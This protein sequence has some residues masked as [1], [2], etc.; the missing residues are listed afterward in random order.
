MELTWDLTDLFINDEAFYEEITNINSLIIKLED[1]RN[2]KFDEDSLYDAL[3]LY[4]EIKKRCNNILVYGSLKY[5]QNVNSN[6]TIKLK[7]DAEVFHNETNLKIQYIESQIIAMGRSKI[8]SLI[9]NNSNL[10]IYEHYLDNLFRIQAHIK[11]E[12]NDVLKENNNEI[13]KMLT[14]YNSIINNISYGTIV[15]NGKEETVTNANIN[16]Y[17]AAS[18]REVRSNAYTLIN[19]AYANHAKEIALILN[20]IYHKRNQNASLEEYDS[21][22]NK[23]LSEENINPEIIKIL[24][25]SI[26]DNLA[27][28]QKY[29]KIKADR[30]NIEHPHLYDYNV[31]LVMDL[32]IEFSIEEAINIIKAA[33]APLGPDYLNTIDYLLSGHIDATLNENKHQSIIFSWNTYSF[34]NY[35]GKYFDLKNL[36]HELGH[37]INYHF[38]KNNLPYLYED[39]SVFVG[40]IASIVNELLLS[41]YLIDHAKNDQEKLFYLS[42]EVE[43]YVTSVYKQVMYTEYENALYELSKNSE[44]TPELLSKEYEKLLH[45]YYGNNTIY[46]QESNIEWTRIGKLFRHSYYSYK[47]ATGLIM[48]SIV[49]NNI[50]NNTLSA[51]D[52]IKFLQSGSS[53]YSLDL[54]KTINIDLS[55]LNIIKTGFTGLEKDINEIETILK[56]Q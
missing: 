29:L 32:N 38:S 43:N 51:D 52:Y 23:V 20:D 56:V 14:D 55:D 41:R 26:N 33:L 46:D 40:E 24:I 9:N 2:Q 15:V 44:L 53:M 37:I 19:T 49:A 6:E 30:I 27:L 10:K 12:A 13:N 16:K 11:P 54:L 3:N 25:K 28:M 5:Y 42:K 21:V 50:L 36:I 7:T 34:L 8:E 1:Y 35:R 39:N 17:L 18:D 4:W 47:Y 22:L 31:P 48:A 45:Q